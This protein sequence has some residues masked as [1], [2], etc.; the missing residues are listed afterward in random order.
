MKLKLSLKRNGRKNDYDLKYENANLKSQLS[1]VTFKLDIIK[2]ENAKLEKYNTI[3]K[4]ELTQA[5][6]LLEKFYSNSEKIDE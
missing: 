6:Q 3:V 1:Q 2:M 5:K 4:G